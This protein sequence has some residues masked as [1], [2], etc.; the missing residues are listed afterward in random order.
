MVLG[1]WKT[2]SAGFQY[3]RASRPGYSGT[4]VELGFAL[5]GQR[6]SGLGVG[7]QGEAAAVEADLG[8]VAVLVGDTAVADA[9]TCPCLTKETDDMNRI[10]SV[11][12]ED[13]HASVMT[14]V[15]ARRERARG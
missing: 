15:Q 9:S 3:G 7:E 5:V 6:D 8:V 13:D 14:F 11:V 4:H 1:L 12:C 2:R 10:T